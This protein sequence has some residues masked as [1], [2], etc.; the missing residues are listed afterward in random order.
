M[1]ILK[2]IFF[3]AA[4]LVGMAVLPCN[5]QYMGGYSDLD[6]SDVTR[7]LKSHVSYLASDALEGRRA[8]SEG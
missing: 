8:G 4:V 6:D 5:A 3:S 1:E 7:A 2:K